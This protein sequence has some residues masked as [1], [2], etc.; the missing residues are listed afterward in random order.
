MFGTLERTQYSILI[1]LK[2]TN[3]KLW[4]SMDK[5]LKIGPR[6]EEKFEK[7]GLERTKSSKNGT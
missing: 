7:R 4:P 2:R 3:E 1:V 5:N 6:A